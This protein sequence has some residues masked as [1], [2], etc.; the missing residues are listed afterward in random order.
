M[1]RHPGR[2]EETDCVE[3]GREDDPRDEAVLFVVLGIHRTLFLVGCRGQ[4]VSSGKDGLVQWI[5]FGL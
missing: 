1:Y 2:L 5:F 3:E 4:R